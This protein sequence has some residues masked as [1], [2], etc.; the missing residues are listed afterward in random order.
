MGEMGEMGELPSPIKA[1][2]RQ[3]T[4]HAAPFANYIELLTIASAPSLRLE[5]V[6]ASLS[7][8]T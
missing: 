6:K 3:L 1:A 8:R 2:R 7:R 4:G 5:P